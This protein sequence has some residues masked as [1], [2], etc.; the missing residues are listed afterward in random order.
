MKVVAV[1]AAVLQMVWSQSRGKVYFI[2][3]SFLMLSTTNANC[4]RNISY[5]SP[6]L[7]LVPNIIIN[8]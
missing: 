8:Y 2:Y 7:V 3:C 4:L 6:R 1:A 5:S